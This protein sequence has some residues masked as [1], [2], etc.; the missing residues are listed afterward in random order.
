MQQNPNLNIKKEKEKDETKPV[1]II[2][3]TLNNII[4]LDGYIKKIIKMKIKL[5]NIIECIKI[6]NKINEIAKNISENLNKYNQDFEDEDEKYYNS[7]KSFET[8]EGYDNCHHSNSIYE[9]SNSAIISSQY[10]SVSFTNKN[11]TLRKPYLNNF[12]ICKGNK[13]YEFL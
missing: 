3:E 11:H 6:V 10:I 13:V 8:L 12:L 2:N 4:N 1:D 9:Y 5:I 7:D